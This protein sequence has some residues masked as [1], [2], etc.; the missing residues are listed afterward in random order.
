MSSSQNLKHVSNLS[1]KPRVAILGC[2]AASFLL[3]MALE[4]NHFVIN[5]KKLIKNENL[6][7]LLGFNH[8]IKKGSKLF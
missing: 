4:E 8:G 1:K 5:N 7:N 3:E 2:F 6:R